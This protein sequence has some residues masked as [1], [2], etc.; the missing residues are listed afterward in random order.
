MWPK[1]ARRC[2]TESAVTPTEEKVFDSP[3]GWVAK[4]VREYV[5][6]DGARGHRWHGA[7]TLL[8]TTRG[9]RSGKLRRTALIYGRDGGRFVVVASQGGANAHPSW[10]LNLVADPHVRVQ[11]GPDRFGARATPATSRQKPRL[12]R[13]MVEIWPEYDRYQAKT[14]R[15]IPVVILERLRSE[16]EG[17]GSRRKRAQLSSAT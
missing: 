6:T 10:Y 5:A 2:D 12:W 17:T 3:R 7:D 16:G 13:R 9:R 1:A 15:D 14:A 8:L 11:V 4:H